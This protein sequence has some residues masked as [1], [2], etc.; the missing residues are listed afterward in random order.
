MVNIRSGL[1]VVTF[2]ADRHHQPGRRDRIARYSE[3]LEQ[4][5]VAQ[6]GKVLHCSVCLD[7]LHRLQHG[8]G[9]LHHRHGSRLLL[10][11]SHLG[12]SCG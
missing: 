2:D 11:R 10:R 1:G 7:I 4:E 12:Q 8:A 6:V 9:V 5:S 3:G